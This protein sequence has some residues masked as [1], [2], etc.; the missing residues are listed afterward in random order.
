MIHKRLQKLW[1][2]LDAKQKWMPHFLDSVHVS[3]LRGIESLKVPFGYPVTVIAGTNGSGKSTV[4]RAAACAYAVPGADSKEFLPSTLFPDYRPSAGRFRDGVSRASLEFSYSTPEGARLMKWRRSRGWGRSFYGRSGAVQPERSV[5]RRSL[6]NLEEPEEARQILRMAKRRP[7]PDE[8][9]LATAQLRFAHQM[10]PFRYSRVVNLAGDRRPVLFSEQE[11]GAAYSELHMAAGERAI[12]RLASDVSQL[13]GALVLIDEVE[14]GLHPWAQQLLMLH[15]QQLALRNDIQVIVTSHSPVVIDSVPRSARILLERDE[16]GNVQS[17]EPHRDVVQDALYGRPHD[18]LNVLCEDDASEGVIRG[19]MDHLVPRL[20]IR[21]DT[22]RIGRNT[23]ASEFPAHAAAFRKFDVIDCFVFVLD[24]DQRGTKIP[25]QIR[26]RARKENVDVLFLPG[27]GA[28]EAW[29]WDR[30]EAD[31]GRW[32][33][34]L[35]TDRQSLARDIRNLNAVF[36]IAQ[37][38]PSEIAKAK[39][40]VLADDHRLFDEELCRIVARGEASNPASALREL[41]KD[42]ETIIRRWRGE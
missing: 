3:E 36:G 2:S 40:Q 27:S 39:L 30:L 16:S 6:A 1:P 21:F 22:I 19:V 14:A 11:G 15:L 9:Q 38:T 12:L 35:N 26:E 4:L 33:G 10:L 41:V 37:S 32:S 28:P 42:F 29:V 17:V 13:K 34:D 7:L 18:T 31:P 24:G 8:T 20:R 23:G 25:D 5:Y